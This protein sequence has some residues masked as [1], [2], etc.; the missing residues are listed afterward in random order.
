MANAPIKRRAT[1]ADVEALPENV[2]GEIVDGELFVMPR[3]KPK[4]ANAAGALLGELRGPF[5]YGR[6]GGPGGW[7][8]LPEPELHLV[9]DEPVV[10]DLAGWRR[11]RMAALPD[12]AKIALAPDCVCEVLSE[13]TEVHDRRDKMPLYARHRVGY[14]WL[15]DPILR[16][17]EAFWNDEGAWRPI[18]AGKWRDGST[19]KV[20]PFE[21]IG[22]DLSLL[23]G[24]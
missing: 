14:V 16:Y 18:A 23:W 17:L 6:G 2:V 5:Q 20:P 13:S 15:V 24:D 3:P 4:H 8:I 10:P 9:H 22:V 21:A 1:Y 7:W 19:V 11:E 12:E